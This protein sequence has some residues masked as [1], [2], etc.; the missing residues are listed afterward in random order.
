MNEFT[1]MTN[2]NDDTRV[3]TEESTHANLSI[4]S[5]ISRRKLSFKEDLEEI[6]Y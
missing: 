4:P 2:N 5:R 3:E 6:L 1:E